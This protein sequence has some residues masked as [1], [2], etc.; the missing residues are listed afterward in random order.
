MEDSE[1][2]ARIAQKYLDLWLEHWAA[3][4]AAPE[5][6]AAMARLMAPFTLQSETNFD[7][8]RERCG[9]PDKPPAFRIAPSVGER[10]A[11]ELE[12]RVA[13]LERRIAELETRT[14][15]DLARPARKPRRPAHKT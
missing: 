10:S 13:A 5:T 2:V 3:C 7:R 11:D 4:L 6:A 12:E 15:P 9:A 14:K 1:E 8:A